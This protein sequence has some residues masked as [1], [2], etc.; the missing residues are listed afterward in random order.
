M[1]NQKVAD[2]ESCNHEHLRATSS[3]KRQVS[4]RLEAALRSTL[5]HMN[6]QWE[7]KVEYAAPILFLKG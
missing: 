1:E 3:Y 4:D 5:S 2:F 6:K 7:K